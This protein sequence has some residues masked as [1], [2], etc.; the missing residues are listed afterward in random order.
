MSFAKSMEFDIGWNFAQP[1][2]IFAHT[3]ESCYI[4]QRQ[5][6]CLLNG[7]I[8]IALCCVFCFNKL[9]KSFASLLDTLPC[10]MYYILYIIYYNIIYY[11]LYNMYYIL[12]IIYHI[13]YII[14]AYLNV[15]ILHWGMHL[16]TLLSVDYSWRISVPNP[17][18]FISNFPKS[19]WTV[20]NNGRM[21]IERD[22]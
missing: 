2:R 15:I 18:T 4:Q 9:A 13:L 20:P 22:N 7:T 3:N 11:I 1:H 10:I 8:I 16:R 19:L 14:N 17:S 12:H 6:Y 5:H 21:K